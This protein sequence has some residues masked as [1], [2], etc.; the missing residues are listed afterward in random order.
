[1]SEVTLAD[2]MEAIGELKVKLVGLD[3]AVRAGDARMTAQ[4]NKVGALEKWAHSVQLAEARAEGVA[5][6]RS[7]VRKQEI[8]LLFGLL[9]VVSSIGG[10][11]VGIVSKLL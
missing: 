4:D 10:L 8:A 5:L 9:T 2:V 6:G 1:M 7:G 11:T 3:G